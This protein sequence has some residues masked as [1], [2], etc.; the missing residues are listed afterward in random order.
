MSALDVCICSS[1]PYHH[2]YHHQAKLRQH[3]QQI[4][5]DETLIS[6]DTFKIDLTEHDKIQTVRKES[7]FSEQVTES[8][9]AIIQQRVA[10][11]Q[12]QYQEFERREKRLKIRK[13]KDV[14]DY[15]SREE[16][17]VMLGD[18]ENDEQEVIVRL[19]QPAYLYEIRKSIAMT[20]HTHHPSDTTKDNAMS[21]EQQASYTQLVQKRSKTLKKTTDETAKKTYRTRPGRLGLDEA[22]KKMQ[23]NSTSSN[24]SGDNGVDPFEGWSSARIRAYQMIEQNPNSYYY[25]F[26]APGEEQR[27][28]PW[29]AEEQALFH[30]RIA[31]VGSKGQWGIFAMKIPGRVGYQCSNYYRLLV[32]THQIQD[33]NYVV[34]A[35]GKAH[36]LF[37]KKKVDGST[38]KAIRNYSKH[39]S[40][41]SSSTTSTDASS[42]GPETPADI[43][44]SVHHHRNR[45]TQKSTALSKHKNKRKRSTFTCNSSD[46]EEEDDEEDSQDTS[47]TFKVRSS[48]TS[49]TNTNNKRTRTRTTRNTIITTTTTNQEENPLPGFIDPITLD[50]VIKPAIST[51]GHVMGY[52]SWVRCLTNWEGRKNI[53]PLTKK[54]LT[55]RDLIVLTPDNIEAYRDKIIQ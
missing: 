30:K 7:V 51:Y 38:E 55:K 44:S 28:G 41:S 53:C 2:H 26:N 43:T 13:V 17:E 54:P 15:L 36:Y 32:E 49:K 20:A 23:D 35:N 11:Q 18:N 29:T 34:D 33:P 47:G 42:S 27:R 45:N 50:E 48:R 40:S 1:R 4:T 8:E 12:R 21:E 16:I 14:Y 24:N 52:D 19:T 25:R 46:E 6:E 3:K 39:A 10:L 5:A 22:L 9:Q 31:E 37:E